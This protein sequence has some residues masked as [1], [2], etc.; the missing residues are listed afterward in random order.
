MVKYEFK[1]ENQSI[2]YNGEIYTND[3]VNKLSKKV[4]NSLMSD[5]PNKGLLKEVETKKEKASDK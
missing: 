2:K 1:K 4:L 3:N 5:K